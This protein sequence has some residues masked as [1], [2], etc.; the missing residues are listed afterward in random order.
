M[1]IIICIVYCG[2]VAWFKLM[3]V[4]VIDKYWDKYKDKYWDW[5]SSEHH[6]LRTLC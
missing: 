1:I 6:R 4:Y 2:Y 3:F 5:T